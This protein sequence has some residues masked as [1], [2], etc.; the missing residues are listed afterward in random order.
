MQAIRLV[1]TVSFLGLFGFAGLFANYGA[2]HGA[3]LDLKKK[4]NPT[5]MSNS[6]S[7]LLTKE[8]L[9]F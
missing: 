2:S 7:T 8:G 1:L 9:T 4:E 5:T 6:I 3:N